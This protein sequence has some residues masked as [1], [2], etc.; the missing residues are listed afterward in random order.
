[1]LT[2]ELRVV[3]SAECYGVIMI[4]K[5]MLGPALETA[6]AICKLF[7]DDFG[8]VLF[9]LRQGCELRA[10]LKPESVNDVCPFHCC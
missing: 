4:P 1:M 7:S 10:L 3:V 2:V 6:T 8:K 9:R 5:P